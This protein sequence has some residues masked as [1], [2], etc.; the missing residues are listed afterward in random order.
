MGI[1]YQLGLSGKVISWRKP[2]GWEGKDTG[3]VFLRSIKKKVRKGEHPESKRKGRLF[4]GLG[5]VKR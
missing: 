1:L 3:G 2:E 5:K 4:I